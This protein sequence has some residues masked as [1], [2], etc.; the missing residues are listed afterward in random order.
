MFVL[1]VATRVPCGF[2]VGAGAVDVE[3]VGA[4]VE[5]D[6]IL[7]HQTSEGLGAPRSGVPWVFDVGVPSS[8][9]LFAKYS[10]DK[11]ENVLVVPSSFGVKLCAL[12]GSS[13]VHLLDLGPGSTHR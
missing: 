7:G 11:H 12:F 3:S 1:L 8:F 9:C 10:L 2:A 13:G 4:L 6:Q 5:V